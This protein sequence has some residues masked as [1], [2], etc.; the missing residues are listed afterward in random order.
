MRKAKNER[1]TDSE[2]IARIR[3]FENIPMLKMM[4]P[5]LLY[6]KYKPMI[7][8]VIA[9][10]GIV[11]IIMVLV[12][13]YF[14]YSKYS[15]TNTLSIMLAFALKASS[16]IPLFTWLDRGDMAMVLVVV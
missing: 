1:S 7:V 8:Q 9:F 14:D 4:S 12:V 5:S 15:T 3:A 6:L 10:H 2:E 11:C 13:A 16:S